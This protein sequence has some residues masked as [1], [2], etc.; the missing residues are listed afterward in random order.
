[1]F[2]FDTLFYYVYLGT[3]SS[4]NP[5]MDGLGVCYKQLGVWCYFCIQ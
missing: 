2:Y 4:Q 1:M 5:R 3:V